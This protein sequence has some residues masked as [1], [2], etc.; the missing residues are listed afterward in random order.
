LI[1]ADPA[2]FIVTNPVFDTVAIDDSMLDHVT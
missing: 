1:R 2:L